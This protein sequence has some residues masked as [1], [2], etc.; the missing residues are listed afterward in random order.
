MLDITIPELK[1]QLEKLK[2]EKENL[3]NILETIKKDTS[4]LKDDWNTMTSESVFTNFDEMYQGYSDIVV[5]IEKDI[6]HIED[7]IRKYEEAE[8]AINREIDNQ[9]AV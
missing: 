4:G 5:N 1:V 7:V 9:V 8:T 6:K 3:D 2:K